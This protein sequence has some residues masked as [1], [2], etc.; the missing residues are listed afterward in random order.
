MYR[1]AKQYSKNA[2]DCVPCTLLNSI[3][4][5]L[6]EVKHAPAHSLMNVCGVKIG[7]DTV[8]AKWNSI[9]HH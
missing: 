5:M 2:T 8:S 4:Q 6:T 9:R 7:S 3:P 1:L